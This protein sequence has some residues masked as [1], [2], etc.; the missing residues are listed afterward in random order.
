VAPNYDDAPIRLSRTYG[1]AKVTSYQVVKFS[2]SPFRA[3]FYHSGKLTEQHRTKSR[4]GSTW[5]FAGVL[6]TPL[7]YGIVNPKFLKKLKYS[8]S[9]PNLNFAVGAAVLRRGL[10]LLRERCCEKEDR[11]V[12]PVVLNVLPQDCGLAA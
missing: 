12:E 3:Q 7:N 5:R 4:H 1:S 11:K 8:R 10:R 2:D 6:L 9:D